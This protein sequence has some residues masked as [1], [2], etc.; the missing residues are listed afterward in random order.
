MNKSILLSV[1]LA[2]F[3][4]GPGGSSGTVY[5]QTIEDEGTPL[6]QRTNVNFTGT[7]VSCTDSGGKTVCTISGGGAG[8]AN[9]VEQSIAITGGGTF[10]QSVVT[11]Q[12]WVSSGS[13]VVCSTFATSVDGLTV[14]AITVGAL[15]IAVSD[16]VAGTGFTINVFSPNGLDGTIRVHCTGA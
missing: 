11:G 13:K 1:L 3:S 10:F 12:T 7:G 6:I 5:N 16:L 8:P 2:G 9:V 15:D 4:P 14:E